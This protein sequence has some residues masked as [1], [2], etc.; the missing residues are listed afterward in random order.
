MGVFSSTF[1]TAYAPYFVGAS[2]TH[3]LKKKNMN[4]YIPYGR[5]AFL[6]PYF[7]EEKYECS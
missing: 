4:T 3:T 1:F 5:G 7:K 2:I 6:T